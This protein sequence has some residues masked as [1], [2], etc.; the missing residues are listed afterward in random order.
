MFVHSDSEMFVYVFEKKLEVSDIAASSL[1]KIDTYSDLEKIIKLFDIMPMCQGAVP[2][3][4][5][6][7]LKWSSSPVESSGMWWHSKC[8]TILP[9]ENSDK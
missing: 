7:D 5:N 2:M 6:R 1:N 4:Q 3:F 8:C 9:K